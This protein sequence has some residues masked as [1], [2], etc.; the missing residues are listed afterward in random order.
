MQGGCPCGATRYQL[1]L[2]P[3]IVHCCHCFD[4]QRQLGSA[5]ALNAVVESSAIT[6][7]SPAPAS[8]PTSHG[9]PTPS[10]CC[11]LPS[12][13]RL[14][15]AD[16]VPVVEAP[17]PGEEEKPATR[18]DLSTIPSSSKVGVT[19]AQCPV[20]HIGLWNH[21]ADIGS[22]AVYLRVGTLD[23]PW[24]IDPDVHVFTASRRR[25][26]HID[27]GKPQFEE[28]YDAPRAIHCRE[29]VLPRLR[30]LE[31][32]G[33]VIR[34][35]REIREILSNVEDLRETELRE[36]DAELREAEVELSEAGLRDSDLRDA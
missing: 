35:R 5:F 7:L 36:A 17:P 32:S 6:L 8:V 26:I 34:Y 27:D 2:P 30:V 3:I 11:L 18:L 31:E 24:E 9:D 25:F 29:E 13:A 22:H 20:C 28:Y 4:C 14:T 1:N 12:Y 33:D 21:Y 10:L 16:P 15:N 23:A 19:L